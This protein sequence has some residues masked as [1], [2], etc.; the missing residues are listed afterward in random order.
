M[1]DKKHELIKGM[2]RIHGSSLAQIGRALGVTTST[3][4]IVAKGHRRSRRIELAIA[5]AIGVA[6]S[7]LWPDRSQSRDYPTS[8]RSEAKLPSSTLEISRE[9]RTHE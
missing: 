2:L 9:E 1:I 5:G 4:S 3:V 6:P 8:S 7:D